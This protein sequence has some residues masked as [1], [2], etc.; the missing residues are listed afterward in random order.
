MA[1]MNIDSCS[2][3][4]PYLGN[5]LELVYKP[6]HLIINNFITEPESK[7]YRA[8]TFTLNSL[9]IK[10]R[11]AHITPTKI[12]QFVTLWKR[13]GTGPI[14]P[15]DLSDPVDLFVITVEN[16]NNHGQFVFPKQLLFEKGIIALQGN[17]GKRALRVYAP[18][19]ITDNRQAKHTQ[20]WQQ[21]YFLAIP[22]H[23]V[24]DHARVKKL[25]AG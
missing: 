18:W 19:D 5:L 25:Y 11:A 20:S 22:T 6:N 14:Q 4:N 23:G 15:Y 21:N 3:L 16:K 17:G 7:K 2:E 8:C 1:H 13:L 10:F 12:G 9:N 24:V